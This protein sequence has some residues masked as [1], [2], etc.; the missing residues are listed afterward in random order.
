MLLLSPYELFGEIQVPAS[1]RLSILIRL[2]GLPY[3]S[4]RFEEV[5]NS[6][7]W[8][9]KLRATNERPAHEAREA[10]EEW[11]H[12]NERSAAD[13]CVAA[14][15]ETVRRN[16]ALSLLVGCSTPITADLVHQSIPDYNALD[17]SAATD[18]GPRF[19][20]F[21][22]RSPSKKPINRFT[23]NFTALLNEFRPEVHQEQII[24]HSARHFVR[25]LKVRSVS[26]SS[27]RDAFLALF[28]RGL[29]T[30]STCMFLW[31]RHCP[32]GGFT[33]SASPLVGDLPPFCPSCGRLARAMASFVPDGHLLDGMRLKDGLLGAAVGWH[34]RKNRVRFAHSLLV[35]ATEI[36]FVAAAHAARS[37]GEVLIECKMLQVSGPP[38][39]LARNLRDSLKQ[40]ADHRA[41]LEAEGR[42]VKQAIC[43]LNLTKNNLLTVRRSGF[44]LGPDG[45]RLVSYEEFPKWL[46]I[47]MSLSA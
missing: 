47:C 33:S 11:S 44:P 32:Q 39:Q 30:A 1:R 41:L 17:W 46:R 23:L 12:Q 36:D 16:G 2:A 28:E 29:V 42:P 37:I 5:Q 13:L 40:L 8:V 3:I 24:I 19:E 4:H 9:L 31:C 14:A 35:G 22:K 7:D 26:E 18:F 38:K 25:L 15:L 27:W 20:A 10:I 21:L 6:I 34:L 45:D 43:V